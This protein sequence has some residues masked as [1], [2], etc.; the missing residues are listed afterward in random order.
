M[1]GVRPVIDSDE[2][3]D[4]FAVARELAEWAIPATRTIDRG[5]I[6]QKENPADLVTDVDTAVE[7]HVRHV[8]GA[9]FPHHAF[10]GEEFGGSAVAGVPTW[11]LDPVDGTTNV[12]NGMPWSAFSLA[13][14]VDEQPLIAV[15]ADPW[16]GEIFDA[17]RGRGARL[18]GRMLPAPRA[19]SLAGSVVSTEL[20]G[21]RPWPGMQHLCENLADRYCTVRVM[22]SGTLSL[23]GVAAGRGAGAVVGRFGAVDHVA[24]ALIA[25]EAGAHV[26]DEAGQRNLFPRSGGM[27]VAAPALAAELHALWCAAL[28]ASAGRSDYERQRY[29]DSGLPGVP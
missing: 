22:G 27:L 26:L 21:H 17:R 28:A 7:R 8:I 16:R 18:D 29:S 12:A 9:R 25:H 15:V 6:S 4:A 14:A 5:A 19:A 23:V 10:V 1:S 3:D 2:T 11:Y 24:A 20:A 13:L